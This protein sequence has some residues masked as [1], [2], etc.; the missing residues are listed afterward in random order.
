MLLD[1]IFDSYCAKRKYD[2]FMLNHYKQSLRHFE[3][4]VL[5]GAGNFSKHII[6]F[7][8]DILKDKDVYF[9][10]KDKDKQGKIFLKGIYCYG[11]DKL[12][13]CK[14]DS[15]IIIVVSPSYSK[16]I[17]KEIAK[18]IPWCND[19][20]LPFTYNGI[21]IDSNFISVFYFSLYNKEKNIEWIY[22]QKRKIYEARECLSD[23]S[24]R[25]VFD[26]KIYEKFSG[27]IIHN[28]IIS[29]SQYFPEEICKRLS[30]NEVFLDCGAYDGDTIRQFIKITTNEYKRVY[31]FELDSEIYETLKCRCLGDSRICVFN[32]G[33]SNKNMEILYSR[34]GCPSYVNTESTPSEYIS[35]GKA[36]SIDAMRVQGVI[37]EGITFVKMDIEGAE[38]DAIH[39]MEQMIREEKPKLAICVYHR[40]SDIWEIPM[41]I[42]SLVPEYRL[43]LRHHSMYES[44]TVLY[45]Y[46]P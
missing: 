43:I 16:E 3:T 36:V 25:I 42:K 27:K 38:M 31:A 28:D 32:L 6:D 29:Q 24:S 40:P 5:A 34:Q 21:A 46:V 17:V 20:V 26:E 30:Q 9:I 2:K 18:P 37:K 35:Y 4:I 10:D 1:D 39:G 45:A 33:V 19:A 12:K 23:D 44:E 7:L 22:S 8:W 14:P 13:E 41:F 11:I 15:T